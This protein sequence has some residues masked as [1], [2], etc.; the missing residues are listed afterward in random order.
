MLDEKYRPAFQRIIA[1]PLTRVCLNREI[2]ANQVTLLSCISGVAVIPAYVFAGAWLA[3]LLLLLSGLLDVLDG[4]IARQSQTDSPLGSLCD[5]LSDRI[6]ESATIIALYVSIEGSGFYCLL[7]M[8]SILLCVTSFLLAAIYT[9]PEGEKSFY[10]SPGLMERAEAFA[11]FIVMMWLPDYFAV[12]SII[13]TLLV[14]Y[15]AWVRVGEIRQNLS[16]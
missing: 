12:L 3:T 7:M 16:E 5:I 11:F 1:D 15:T 4:S 8:A 6:V 9:A 13:F 14:S 10:Y 2:T